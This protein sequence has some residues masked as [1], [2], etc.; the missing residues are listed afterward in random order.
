M[1]SHR[2]AAARAAVLAYYAALSRAE[3][4]QPYQD[5]SLGQ[6][7]ALWAVEHAQAA[8][9]DAVEAL[10]AVPE[11]DDPMAALASADLGSVLIELEQRFSEGGILE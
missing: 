4:A 2:Y 3:D 5:A 8:H 1:S 6:W 11:I 10:Q 9:I 7:G